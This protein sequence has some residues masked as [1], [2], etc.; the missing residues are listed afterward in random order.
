M[1]LFLA[2][3]FLVYGSV[4]AY[5]LAKAKSAFGFGW[6]TA[7]LLALPLAAFT[8][9][10]LAVYA[11]ARHDGLEAAARAASW[12]AYL[13]MGFLF[14]FLWTGLAADAAGLLA[15]LVRGLSGKAVPDPPLAGRTA[16][17]V[18]AALSV[19]LAAFG[20]V[21]AGRIRV[22]RIDVRTDRL[23]PGVER[24]TVAQISDVHLGLI[25]REGRARAIA[26]AVR[27]AR[28]DLVVSTGDFVDAEINH[29]DGLAEL[30]AAIPAPLG[31]FAVTGNHE[32]YA[33]IAHA[34]D[35][36]RRAGFTVLRQE[37][38]AP[39]GIVRIAGVDDPAGAAFGRRPERGEADLLGPGGP[40]RP[41]T[42]LLKHRPRV[43]AEAAGLFDLQLSGHTH[44]GQ[45]F[46]FGL[47]VRLAYPFLEGLRDAGKGSLLH[48]SRGTG[49]WGPPMRL[50]APPQVT[51]VVV[52]RAPR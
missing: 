16:F 17:L 34:L 32:Y 35:F 14:F 43:A 47:F 33:G 52:E 2:T 45:M 44:A 39:G 41:F 37:T 13:W 50:L 42:I 40:D 38:A 11:L 30:F 22:E 12:A 46:P 36:T 1:S 31:K 18:L 25:V 15:R 24:V 49:T 28:P 20:A 10:P 5:F 48:T 6:G 19:A 4:H 51:V 26:E 23:P 9:G 29:L 7:L 8:A 21:E 27:S 3:F